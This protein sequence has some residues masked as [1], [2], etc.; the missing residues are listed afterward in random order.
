MKV[1]T[2]MNKP[3]SGESEWI[4][5]QPAF[6]ELPNVTVVYI[7]TREA[8]DGESELII[9]ISDG[10]IDALSPVSENQK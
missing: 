6:Q 1:K 8:R 7:L 9:S 10:S 2:S 4:R 5:I 3:H